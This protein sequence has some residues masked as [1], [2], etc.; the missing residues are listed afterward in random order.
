[1]S[2]PD[3][4]DYIEVADRI[5]AF[6]EAHPDGSLCREEWHVEEVAGQTFVVYTAL[7]YRRPDDPRPGV[8]TA[9]EP[10]P[11]PTKFT[12]DSELMNAETA[13]WGRAIASLGFEVRK[14]ASR[15]EVRNR[16][17]NEGASQRGSSQRNG[18]RK[19]TKSQVNLMA[20]KAKQAGLNDANRDLLLRNRFGVE[21]LEDMPFEA[22]DKW[23]EAIKEPIP[24]G[25]S[26][27]PVEAPE[28]PAQ[29]ADDVPWDA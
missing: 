20:L 17:G 2:S 21:Q 5:K 14:V 1:V 10:F 7:A 3:L 6:K 25:E 28:Q 13:A 8:G 23:L 11:G 18:G 12:K 4:S 16:S 26:D 24:T 9:W 22:V 27:I 15:E 29:T 19:V